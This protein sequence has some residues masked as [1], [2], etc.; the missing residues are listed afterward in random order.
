MAD[1]KMKSLKD[2]HFILFAI[3]IELA[4]LIGLLIAKQKQKG[5]WQELEHERL[6]I[7]RDKLATAHKE[8]ERRRV[9]V[10]VLETQVEY[11]TKKEKQ[12][13]GGRNWKQNY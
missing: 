4:I 3:A 13:E 8:L 1:K 10:E 2:I 7:L 11:L 6:S 5:R 9:V 12:K